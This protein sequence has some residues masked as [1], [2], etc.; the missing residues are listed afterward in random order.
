M[1]LV[2]VHSLNPNIQIDLKYATPDNFTGQVVYDFAHCLLLES[3]AR[4][5]DDVQR[6]LELLGLGLKIWDGYRPIAAQWK[7][8]EICPDPRYVSDPRKGGRHT[9]GTAVDL[10][11]VDAEGHELLMPTAFDDFT[12]KAHRNYTGTSEEALRN[13]TLLQ[14]VMERH[15]FT[16]LAT[17]WWHFDFKGWENCP[18]IQ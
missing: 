6:E 9:R 12:E 5:L 3:V 11:L 4:A 10:T 13:R 18:V 16:G 2:N 15:G 1:P 14:T 8:W 17:E 7:F